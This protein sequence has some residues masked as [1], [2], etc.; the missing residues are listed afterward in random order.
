MLLQL[1]YHT[2]ITHSCHEGGLRIRDKD[3]DVGV[4]AV[5][6]N[7]LIHIG[8]HVNTGTAGRRRGSAP[9]ISKTKE[10]RR[11]QLYTTQVK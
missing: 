5:F 9:I 3:K 4:Q 8:V 10:Y 1:H 7:P 11:T 2:H 6:V